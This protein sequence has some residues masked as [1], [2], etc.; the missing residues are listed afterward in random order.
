[1]SIP[2]TEF[3]PKTTAIPGLIVFD[4]TS[5]IDERGY[6]QEKYQK[7]KLVAAGL[8]NDFTIVQNSL[9]YNKE[10]GVTR[11]I[12]AEPW[13][14]YIS[15][16]TGRVFAAY[17]D[18]RKGD[19]FGKIV[20]IE[21]TPNVTVY[22]PQGVGNSFQTLEPDT[23]YQYSVT[24]HWSGDNYDK[25]C[26]V[27]AADPELAIQWPISLDQATLSERDR[28]HPQLSSVTPLEI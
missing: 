12:H 26:F 2:T 6:F 1:M 8:P 21:I 10:A 23:Y 14:K 9:S 15:V 7:A 13:D 5:V 24:A 3:T 18:L 17:V 20:T 27:N 19:S 11:G 22:L 25:Y 4:V 16:I 28:L